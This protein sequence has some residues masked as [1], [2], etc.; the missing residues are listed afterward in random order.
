MLKNVAK[1]ISITT[2]VAWEKKGVWKIIKKYHQQ[3]PLSLPNKWQLERKTKKEAKILMDDIRQWRQEFVNKIIL[4]AH[5]R[6]TGI[7]D[8]QATANIFESN[9]NW[10]VCNPSPWDLNGQTPNTTACY[11][12]VH[13]QQ[14]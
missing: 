7:G 9:Y 6:F 8:I 14:C 3:T 10:L 4:M 11:L 2:Q 5:L 13:K 12:Q 1:F